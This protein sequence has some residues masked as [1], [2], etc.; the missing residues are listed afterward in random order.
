MIIMSKKKKAERNWVMINKLIIMSSDFIYDHQRQ[1][2]T[3]RPHDNKLNVA[4]KKHRQ[5]MPSVIIWNLFVMFLLIFFVL[6]HVRFIAGANASALK[7]MWIFGSVMII[8]LG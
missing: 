2:I 8:L 7:E 3:A 5:N 6:K 4:A 1:L